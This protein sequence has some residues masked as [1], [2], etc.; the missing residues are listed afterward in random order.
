M[1]KDLN[2]QIEELKVEDFESLQQ[3]KKS[4]KLFNFIKDELIIR[5][6]QN[7]FKK[8]YFDL[9]IA[10]IRAVVG[11]AFMTTN[12]AIDFY[13]KPLDRLTYRF[14]F[15]VYTECMKNDEIMGYNFKYN[16][17]IPLNVEDKEDIRNYEMDIFEAEENKLLLKDL[18]TN[19][20]AE[21]LEDIDVNFCKEK[22]L[23]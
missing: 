21:V 10:S 20:K 15:K 1:F 3:G 23:N 4:N 14:Y 12:G 13:I 17:N 11:L 2:K 16:L 8:S 18:K 5:S 22:T 9:N 7:N 19:K 6:Y